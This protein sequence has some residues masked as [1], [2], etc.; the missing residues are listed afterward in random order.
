MPTI[1]QHA[2]GTFSWPELAT[3]DQP[4]AKKFY[5]ALFGWG[6]DDSPM[7]ESEVYTMLSI[8]GRNVGALY[9]QQKEER[10]HGVPPHW[11]SYVSVENAD[12]SAAKA[13][14]LGGTVIAE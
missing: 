14:Q 10:A 2:P 3:T 6:L 12:E 11:S 13:K 9:S 7:G 4:G 1:T 8:G 5:S